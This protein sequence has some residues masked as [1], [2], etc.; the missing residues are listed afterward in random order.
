MGPMP[1]L[2]FLALFAVGVAFAVRATMRGLRGD[3]FYVLGEK[4]SPMLLVFIWAI[5]LV[6]FGIWAAIGLGFITDYAS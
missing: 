5:F 1:P 3:G 6:V 2:W 4:Q